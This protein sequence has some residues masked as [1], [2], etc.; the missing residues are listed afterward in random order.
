MLN[1]NK[2][3]LKELTIP[4]AIVNN[5]VK[6]ITNITKF[7]EA[8]C[9]QCGEKLMLKNGDVK[10]KH[11]AHYPNSN[12]VY[13]DEREY[14]HRGNGESYEHKYAKEFYLFVVM[15]VLAI[16]VSL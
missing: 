4:F 3:K 8:Y 15:R 16:F 13:K 2:D 14:K 1:E 5:K 9:L 6:S 11:L 7:D 10:I 12:C